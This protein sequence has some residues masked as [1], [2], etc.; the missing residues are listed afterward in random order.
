MVSINR[1][2]FLYHLES[3]VVDPDPQLHNFD[4]LDPESHPHQKK[5]GS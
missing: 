1:S 5:F 4:N 3:S 2:G